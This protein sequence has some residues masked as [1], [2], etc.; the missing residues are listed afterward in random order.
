MTEKKKINILIDGRNFTVVGSDNEEYVRTLAVYVDKKIKDLSSKNDRLCQ[1][2]SATLAALNIADELHKKKSELEELEDQ[3]K[4]PMEKYGSVIDELKDAKATI[5]NLEKQCEMYKDDLLKSK[6]DT[7]YIT[8]EAIGYEQA[9][10]LK[11]KELIDS[12]KMIKTLQDKVFNN[13]IELIE[14]KKELGEVIR[15]LDYEKN[16]F[17]KEEV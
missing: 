16:I 5:E 14:T 7:D 11:E 10:E 17:A 15:R 4:D 1:T 8:K 13:Q 12:Q 9:L 6:M 2:M 3:S